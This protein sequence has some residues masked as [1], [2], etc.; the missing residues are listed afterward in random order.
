MSGGLPHRHHARRPWHGN[1]KE[2]HGNRE[3][4][5]DGCSAQDAANGF[6][7]QSE[8][9]F[10]VPLFPALPVAQSNR[11]SNQDFALKDVC[12]ARQGIRKP[13]ARI[14]VGA[15][16]QKRL[17]CGIHA[18]NVP[19]VKCTPDLFSFNECLHAGMHE[20]PSWCM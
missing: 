19:M 14:C 6:E 3:V 20:H 9:V 16:L 18:K 15:F 10:H 17:H 7:V 4:V 5:P 13:L 12:P 1:E 11:R 2:S 8:F